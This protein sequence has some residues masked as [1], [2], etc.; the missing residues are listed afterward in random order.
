MFRPACD[1]A[2]L[3]EELLR[4]GIIIRPLKSYGLPHLLRVSVGSPDEN[5]AFLKAAGEIMSHA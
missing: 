5:A 3:F 4:R 2:H 1:A